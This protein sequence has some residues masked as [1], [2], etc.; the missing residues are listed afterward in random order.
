MSKLFEEGIIGGC[1]VKNRIVRSATEEYM[2][3]PDG[4]MREEC[5]GFFEKLAAG[6][7]GAIVLGHAFVFTAGRCHPRM[8]GVHDDR[9]VES[10]AGIKECIKNI[11]KRIMVIGQINHGGRL[12][13]PEITEPVAPSAVRPRGMKTV[14]REMTPDEIKDTI[15]KFADAAL[16]VKKAGLDGVQLHAAHGYLVSQ[17]MSPY[18]NRRTDEWGGDTASRLKFPREI[19]RKIIEYVGSDFP[20]MVKINIADFVPGGLEP[21]EGLEM[22]SALVDEGICA[23]EPSCAIA[24][25]KTINGAARPGITDSKKE[26]YL[27]PYADAL[28][29]NTGVTVIAIGGMRSRTVMERV[30]E[31]GSVDY[32]SMSRPLIREPD[33]PQKI[34]DGKER[35]DC[36][37][38]NSCFQP[39]DKGV[40]CVFVN[41][42][43]K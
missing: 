32:I 6:G 30:L 9:M 38:C 27:L 26:A 12:S 5:F 3:H 35:A 2:A 10:F 17:F 8:K 14:P 22:V 43:E 29:K 39:G 24:E 34:R 23:V 40:R 33:L 19:I 20:L 31:Q 42:G 13:D 7:C 41:G 25:T 15:N 21:A 1:I 16:R 36:V 28:K 37:S 11:D 4:S 18:T